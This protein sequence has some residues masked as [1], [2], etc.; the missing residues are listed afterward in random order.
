MDAKVPGGDPYAHTWQEVMIQMDK[1][2][3][4]RQR[5]WRAARLPMGVALALSAYVVVVGAL[6]EGK[7]FAWVHLS[8]GTLIG[9]Y[10]GTG[11][12]I[13]VLRYVFDEWTTTRWRATKMG[14]VAGVLL[15]ATFFLLYA[16]NEGRQ[17][18][19]GPF[20]LYLLAVGAFGAIV[21]LRYWEPPEE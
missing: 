3:I 2:S 6:T 15:G 11:I 14:F 19:L 1:S 9:F 21:G 16:L 8:Q 10:L 5:I 12:Y 4:R 20:A 13:S 7:A 17:I 18:P